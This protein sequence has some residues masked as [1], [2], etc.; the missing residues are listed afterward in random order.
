[1]DLAIADAKKSYGNAYASIISRDDELVRLEALI[2]VRNGDTRSKLYS[3]CKVILS[4]EPKH[5]GFMSFILKR[6]M[7]R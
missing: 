5:R 6:L 2:F 7:E 3:P 4:D 1:M